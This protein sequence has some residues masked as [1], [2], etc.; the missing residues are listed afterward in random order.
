VNQTIQG[1]LTMTDDNW[2]G[3][4]AAAGR[5]VFDDQA[6]DYISFMN[7]NVGIGGT[8]AYGLS[9]VDSANSIIQIKSG[10]ASWGSVYFGDTDSPYDGVIQY[11]HSSRH[12]DFYTA[13][14]EAMRIDQDG[15]VGI[16]TSSPG[17]LLDVN[18]GGGHMI[19]D[20]YDTHPSFFEKKHDI[21][22]KSSVGFL[23]KI[24]NTPIYKFKKKPFVSAEEI[25]EAVLEEFGETVWKE[26]FPEDNSHRQKALYNMP[27][28]KLKTWI[29]EWCS[30]KRAERASLPLWKQDYLGLIYDDSDT[31]N[32]MDEIFQKDDDGETIKSANTNSYIAMLH[33][34]VQELSA[35]VEAL[36][37]K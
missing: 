33:L 6:T 27:E 15:N 31:V 9:V 1:N 24:T 21:Q 4:G 14:V 23:E 25:K 32:N 20:G 10:N 17:Q 3:L 28:G 36:E 7:C 37:N 35:K 5:M 13:G 34:A 29:D 26:Y 22:L 16:G 11:N 12:M 8:P 18:S 19:A 2:I 30:T